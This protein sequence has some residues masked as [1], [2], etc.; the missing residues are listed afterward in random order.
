VCFH[1]FDLFVQVIKGQAEVYRCSA[2][3]EFFSE[4]HSTIPPTT[5]DEIIYQLARKVSSMIVGEENIKLL[6]IV[7]G[8]E[9]FA[10]YLEK[11]PGSFFFLG[12]KNEKSGSIYSAHSPHFFIDEDVHPIG[13]AIHAAFALSYYSYST[14]SYL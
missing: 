12:I 14:N 2:E 11:V 4:E 13:A 5:N 1:L 9:D 3:V 10:F 7:T 6:P 8:S